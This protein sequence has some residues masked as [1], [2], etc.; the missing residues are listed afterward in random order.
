MQPLIKRRENA[1]F[2]GPRIDFTSHD[3]LKKATLTHDAGR[4][5][6]FFFTEP[7]EPIIVR[8]GDPLGLRA[9]ADQF[10]E[11]VGPDLS[12][13]VRDARWITIL[14][15]SMVRAREAF[16]AHGGRNAR[17]NEKREPQYAWLRPLE[18]MWVARTIT[19]ADSNESD[20]PLA[21][22]RSVRPWLAV[23]RRKVGT[24]A[25]RERLPAARQARRACVPPRRAA[26][27]VARQQ[28]A[29]PD[30]A[31]PPPGAQI[32]RPAKPTGPCC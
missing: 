21:G 8:R 27:T 9:L 17:D 12:N 2:S 10:A 19:L 22:Q 31:Q 29:K 28:P 16:H 11:A 24:P 20:R 7:W 26:E 25:H 32:K 3:P 6:R 23:H 13:R 18:L 4:A 5:Y 30:R 14:A 15:W 1:R